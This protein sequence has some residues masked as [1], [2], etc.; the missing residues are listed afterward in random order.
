MAKKRA[1]SGEEPS[2]APT[3]RFKRAKNPR[4]DMYKAL[5]S[6]TNFPSQ[7]DWEDH[8]TEQNLYKALSHRIRDLQVKAATLVSKALVG[9]ADTEEPTEPSISEE[10]FKRHLE[11]YLFPALTKGDTVSREGTF[12]VI[13]KILSALLGDRNLTSTLYP[14]LTFDEFLSMLIRFTP[15]DEPAVK[16]DQALGR[17]LGL[18]CFV[19]QEV[20]ERD[21]ERW[22][23]LLPMLLDLASKN[24]ELRLA[25]GAIVADAVGKLS[26]GQ[27]TWTITTVSETPLAKMAEGLAIWI[28][29]LQH[30]PDLKSDTWK[31]PVSARSAP[32]V[33]SLLKE[34]ATQVLNE[35]SGPVNNG[36]AT[37][38]APLHFVWVKL[39]K[40]FGNLGSTGQKDLASIWTPVVEDY[41]FSKNATDLQKAR[42]FSIFQRMLIEVATDRVLV[43]TIFSRNLMS[44]LQN[45]ASRKDRHL[46]GIAVETLS[47]IA[48]LASAKPKSV[49]PILSNLLGHNGSYEFDQR[50]NTKTVEQVLKPTEPSDMTQVLE[51]LEAPFAKSSSGQEKL[52]A[53]GNAYIRYLHNLAST[54]SSI[55]ALQKLST[56]AFGSSK[57]TSKYGLTDSA[58][59]N[60]LTQL[61]SALAKAGKT[62]ENFDLL[63]QLVVGVKPKHIELDDEIIEQQKAAVETLGMILHDPKFVLFGD[64]QLTN[65]LAAAYAMPLF[66]VYSRVPGAETQLIAI[67]SLSE[68]CENKGEDAGL[69]LVILYILLPLMYRPSSLGRQV[70]KH[71]FEAIGPRLDAGTM[72]MLLERLEFTEDRSGFAELAEFIDAPEG[73]DDEEDEAD[74]GSESRKDEADSDEDE[75]ESG[76]ESEGSA[77]IDQAELLKALGSHLLEANGKKDAE[78]EEDDDDDSE[79]EP[80]MSDSEMMAMNDQLVAAFDHISGQGANEAHEAKKAMAAVVQFKNRI[81]DLVEA[82]LQQQPRNTQVTFAL[83]PYLVRLANQTKSSDIRARVTDVL[84]RYRKRFLKDRK[85]WLE[86]GKRKKQIPDYIT[87]LEEVHK[88]VGFRDSQMF[89]KAASAACLTIAAA[90]VAADQQKLGELNKMHAKLEKE[91]TSEKEKRKRIH[92]SF[93]QTWQAYQLSVSSGAE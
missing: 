8:Q 61:E 15:L 79:S 40:Y 2:Q 20:L 55:Q 28:A 91:L 82:Y 51:L 35:N 88:E 25:C 52:S 59:A 32:N 31:K 24:I 36:K 46:H 53:I 54:G 13:S 64:R 80:D 81:L 12:R 33:L 77:D 90:I 62:A 29:A 74:E 38:S 92:K 16:D 70:S 10:E 76:D 75:E 39:A 9:Q 47:V 7:P 4:D 93:F 71:I 22:K 44:C 69:Q 60:C 50:T 34:S 89:A 65:S 23:K 17:L 11:I 86:D 27:A 18:R 67:N 63:C 19:Q 37:W 3:K 6:F 68:T 14:S 42:G 26:K 30:H 85:Q 48:E 73:S 78:G 5:E 56:L 49:V 45:H 58:K 66:M 21:T 83:L 57:A 41:L 72:R 87:C 43:S 1:P 84:S